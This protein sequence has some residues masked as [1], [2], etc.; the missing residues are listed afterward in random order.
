M[1]SIEPKAQYSSLSPGLKLP[2]FVAKLGPA[3]NYYYFFA[4]RFVVCQVCIV[5]QQLVTDLRKN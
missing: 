4:Y 2:N 3:Y 5:G 1:A